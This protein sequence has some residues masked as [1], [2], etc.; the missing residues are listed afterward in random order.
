MTSEH[1][2][3]QCRE[4]VSAS[5][6]DRPSRS[7]SRRIRRDWRKE[8]RRGSKLQ[9]SNGDRHHFSVADPIGASTTHDGEYSFGF[10]SWLARDLGAS[11]DYT[12]SHLKSGFRPSRIFDVL[13]RETEN[14]HF[15]PNN[16]STVTCEKLDESYFAP[17]KVKY[18]LLTFCSER[19]MFAG[20]YYRKY[21]YRICNYRYVSFRQANIS[22]S[23]KW[24]FESSN[25]SIRF[26]FREWDSRLVWFI[27]K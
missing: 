15:F 24:N 16:K 10:L 13:P 4:E 19:N 14:L 20:N 6:T 23:S 11:I 7:R 9:S 26:I 1:H 12:K 5:S 25:F 3:Q 22:M 17:K 27:M 18:V 21:C 2:G 8:G